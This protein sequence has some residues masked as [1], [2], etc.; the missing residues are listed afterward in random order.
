MLKYSAFPINPRARN[1]GMSRKDN[2]DVVIDPRGFTD[3][4]DQNFK[5]IQQL[6]DPQ[7]LGVD[8]IF[9]VIATK[10]RLIGP[11]SS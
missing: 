9:C 8:H 6:D 11:F 7:E 1:D 2:L 3:D 10:C 4:D 5:T